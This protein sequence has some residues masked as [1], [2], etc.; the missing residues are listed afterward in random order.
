MGSKKAQ[1]VDD[2]N[3]SEPLC[4][5][6]NHSEQ[7]EKDIHNLIHFVDNFASSPPCGVAKDTSNYYV[8]CFPKDVTCA[9]CKVQA[10]LV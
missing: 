4:T 7:G 9:L 5:V 2:Q 1:F 10:R 3:A 6:L 8:T